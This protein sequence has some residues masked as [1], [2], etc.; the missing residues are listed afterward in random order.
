MLLLTAYGYFDGL[1]SINLYSQDSDPA[2]ARSRGEAMAALGSNIVSV[3]SGYPPIWRVS[4]QRT[5]AGLWTCISVYKFLPVNQTRPGSYCGIGIGSLDSVVP[6]IDALGVLD[7]AT[8]QLLELHRSRDLQPFNWQHLTHSDLGISEDLLLKIRESQ[9]PV[10]VT[11]GLGFLNNTQTCFL[12]TPQASSKVAFATYFESVLQ[13]SAFQPYADVLISDNA[14]FFTMR[15]DTIRAPM[16]D[17]QALA[18]EGD[19]AGDTG[20]A[21]PVKIPSPVPQHNEGYQRTSATIETVVDE[22]RYLKDGIADLGRKVRSMREDQAD[23][24]TQRHQKL[25]FYFMLNAIFSAFFIAVSAISLYLNIDLYRR[26]ELTSTKKETA[27]SASPPIPFEGLMQL[28]RAFNDELNNLTSQ[29]KIEF[30]K[31]F[32]GLQSLFTPKPT[33]PAL[34]GGASKSPPRQ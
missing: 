11:A 26:P 10:G 24:S 30:E 33:V 21:S 19:H 34:S 17:S 18:A 29:Q 6:A 22:I 14:T 16:I 28:L 4:R 3:S 2:T 9:T 23:E 31:T 7:A 15:R 1:R 27:V 13:H 8:D 5:S 32:L 25:I 20:P 12:N